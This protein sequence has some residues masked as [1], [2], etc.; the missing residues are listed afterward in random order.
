MSQQSKRQGKTFGIVLFTLLLWGIASLWAWN[1]FA[2]DLL[3][4]PEMKYR[5][6]LAL[7][8]LLLSAGGLLAM[9]RWISRSGRA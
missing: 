3:G 1:T 8:I 6:A 5:H 4:L 7:G 9:P 2:A